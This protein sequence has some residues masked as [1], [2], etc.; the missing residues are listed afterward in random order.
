MNLEAP[1]SDPSLIL[2]PHQR[3]SE[4]LMCYLTSCA[5]SPCEVF[6][7]QR[8]LRASPLVR[9]PSP[10]SS[11]AAWHEERRV[12]PHIDPSQTHTHIPVSDY[13][14]HDHYF[15]TTREHQIP[16]FFKGKVIHGCSLT[17]VAEEERT[18]LASLSTSSLQKKRAGRIMVQSFQAEDWGQLHIAGRLI[19]CSRMYTRPEKCRCCNQTQN[20]YIAA[21][22]TIYFQQQ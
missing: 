10:A 16:L 22:F 19:N 15:L 17:L 21:L 9:L 14:L 13:H 2:S 4:P 11:Q 12:C 3:K 5:P 18:N 20:M 7:E 8:S 6:T 1:E